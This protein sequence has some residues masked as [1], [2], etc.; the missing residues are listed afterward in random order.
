MVKVNKLL[1]RICCKVKHTYRIILAHRAKSMKKSERFPLLD[2]NSKKK[3]RE[4]YF[5]PM[6]WQPLRPVQ[7]TRRKIDVACKAIELRICIE[8]VWRKKSITNRII[9]STHRTRPKEFP[10]EFLH[11][12][13]MIRHTHH[14]LTS[15][16]SQQNHSMQ[17]LIFYFHFFRYFFCHIV[18]KFFLL[19]PKFVVFFSFVPSNF[20]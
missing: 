18:H 7:L 20:Y 3:R 9:R 4:D 12:I 15:I 10:I 2:I 11:M 14:V 19:S 8:I 1:H 13:F 16:I 17:I 6:N 5:I